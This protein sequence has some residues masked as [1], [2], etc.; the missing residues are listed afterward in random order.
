MLHR[1]T[2][3][4]AHIFPRSGAMQSTLLVLTWCLFIVWINE[5][6]TYE[7]NS[8]PVILSICCH[9]SYGIAAIAPFS[10]RLAFD[11]LP[12]DLQRLRCKVNFQ[13]LVFRPHIISLG[14]TLVKRLRSPVPGHSDEYIHQVVEQ[15]TIEDGKYAVLH[16]RFD[17]AS[18]RKISAVFMVFVYFF[19]TSKHLCSAISQTELYFSGYGCTFILWLWRW[20]NWK[21]SSR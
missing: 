12:A 16:L 3:K 5:L 18:R 4:V 14:E 1:I 13:A 10:H 6:V 15:S 7:S 20:Q 17:K 21:I 11:D 2:K 19:S 8:S 9:C